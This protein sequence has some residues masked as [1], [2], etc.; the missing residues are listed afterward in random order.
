M[1]VMGITDERDGRQAQICAWATAAFS[2]EEATSLPQRGIRLLEEAVE[3]F[4]ACGGIEEAAHRL[5]GFV[6]SRPPGEIGQELG[7]VGVTVLALAAAAGLSAD[8]EERREVER[9]LSKP[10]EEFTKRN[11][12]KNA[13]GFLLVPVPAA[14]AKIVI[15]RCPRCDGWTMF[16]ADPDSQTAQQWSFIAKR[17]GDIVSLIDSSTKPSEFGHG[18]SDAEGK[19][20]AERTCQRLD[21]RL[22][23]S[24]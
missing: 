17:S 14:E 1:L 6:F 18:C 3:A 5:V 10:I 8:V 15:A 7:G 13:A 24:P 9:I 12:A 4:Q 11:E 21:H 22:R 2:A 16:H 20:V 19:D 23:N